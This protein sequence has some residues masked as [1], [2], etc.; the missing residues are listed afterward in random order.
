MARRR[1]E[2]LRQFAA[3][4]HVMRSLYTRRSGALCAACFAALRRALSARQTRRPKILLCMLGAQ[5]RVGSLRCA[6]TTDLTR[7][8]NS[9]LQG[10]FYRTIRLMNNGIKPVYVFDGK[11]PSMKSGELVTFFSFH[12]QKLALKIEKRFLNFFYYFF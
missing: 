10:M 5:L 2:R 3:G 9:H 4:R 11:P 8:N 7:E 6:L 1:G 12:F